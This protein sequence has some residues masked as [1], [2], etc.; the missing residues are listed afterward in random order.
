MVYFEGLHL[1]G[2]GFASA[3]SEWFWEFTCRRR[4]CIGDFNRLCCSVYEVRSHGDL[5][6]LGVCGVTAQ[7]KSRTCYLEFSKEIEGLFT[8]F[9]SRPRQETKIPTP[10]DKVY[11]D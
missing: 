5:A 10:K 6:N 7:I 9:L 2:F 1:L 11:H 8:I 3:T 4:I